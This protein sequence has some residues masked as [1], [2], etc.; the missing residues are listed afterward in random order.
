MSIEQV[1]DMLGDLDILEKWIWLRRPRREPKRNDT[2][3]QVQLVVLFFILGRAGA[4]L[5]RSFFNRD[6][7]HGGSSHLLV[8]GPASVVP[9]TG[10]AICSNR[11]N[12]PA[13]GKANGSTMHGRY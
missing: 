9:S 1:T 11:S 6:S 4:D 3:P 2:G 10:H 7:E 8:G 12:S 5:G 13:C